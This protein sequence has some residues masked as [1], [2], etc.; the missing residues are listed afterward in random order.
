MS[1]KL[2]RQNEY[3]IPIKLFILCNSKSTHIFINFG[4]KLQA[5]FYFI[6]KLMSLN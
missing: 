5:R 3:E 1:I 2:I 4:I 6:L